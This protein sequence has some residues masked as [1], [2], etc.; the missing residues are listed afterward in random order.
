M[1]YFDD[2]IMAPNIDHTCTA[3]TYHLWKRQL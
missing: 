3:D 2:P 1:P